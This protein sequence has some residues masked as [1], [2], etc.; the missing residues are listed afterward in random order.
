[1]RV[2][3]VSIAFIADGRI[4]WARAYGVAAAGSGRKVT[5]ATRFQAGSMSKAV[6]AAGALRLVD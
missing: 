5:P 1:M 2:P 3:A 6:A 4:R